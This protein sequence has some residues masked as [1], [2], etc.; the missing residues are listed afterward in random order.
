MSLKLI[1]STF[2]V[3]FFGCSSEQTEKDL[4]NKRNPIGFY[5]NIL[6]KT[7]IIEVGHLL[8]NSDTYLDKRL[9][10]SGS[11]IEVCPMRGCWV[12]IKDDTSHETIRV[13]V[14]DGE[15]VFPLS[16]VGNKIIAEGDFIKLELS[17]KQA[18]NWKHHLAFEKGT[19]LDTSDIVLSAKD[20]YEY[21][22][23]STA[24][25]IF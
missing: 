15:I 22:L 10:V 3:I 23:N 1:F 21:R 25:E 24:A 17:E 20:Y 6:S 5:G 7:E 2:L 4:L 13:K 9:L 12:Q 19:K 18:K 8:S 11:I 16:A 14:T